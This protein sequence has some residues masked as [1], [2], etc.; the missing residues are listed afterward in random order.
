MLITSVAKWL[1]SNLKI[2]YVEANKEVTAAYYIVKTLPVA[3][4]IAPHLM[5]SHFVFKAIMIS[6]EQRYSN[7]LLCHYMFRFLLYKI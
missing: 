6:F 5:R 7:I 2:W 1:L 4:C 3:F